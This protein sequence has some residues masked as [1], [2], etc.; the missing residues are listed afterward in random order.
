MCYTDFQ[1]LAGFRDG[2]KIICYDCSDIVR[3]CFVERFFPCEGFFGIGISIDNIPGC[4]SDFEIDLG[5]FTIGIARIVGI[6]GDWLSNILLAG[7]AG[8]PD[9]AQGRNIDISLCFASI[10]RRFPFDIDRLGF[11]YIRAWLAEC[12]LP[13]GRIGSQ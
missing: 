5:D 9:L 12:G 8:C 2:S 3:S 6:N 13:P 10:C 7:K 1:R 4:I 11:E